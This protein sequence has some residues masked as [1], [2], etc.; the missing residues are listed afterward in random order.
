MC[1]C[2]LAWLLLLIDLHLGFDSI[3]ELIERYIYIYISISCLR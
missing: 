3:E 1:E 2:A